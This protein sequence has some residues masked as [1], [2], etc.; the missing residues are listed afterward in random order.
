MITGVFGS[1]TLSGRNISDKVTTNVSYHNHGVPS[2]NDIG[3]E[4]N[5]WQI[6][7]WKYLDTE[8][9]DPKLR[10]LKLFID[11][12][13]VR[14]DLYQE[15]IN[16]VRQKEDY[17]TEI[18]NLAVMPDITEL[19]NSLDFTKEASFEELH[20]YCAMRLEAIECALNFFYNFN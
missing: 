3:F 14:L 16:P 5:T 10:S 8:K 13:G 20:N 19:V 4:G 9:D 2:I 15:I 18:V 12:N 17:I 6:E 1:L 7:V 11:S